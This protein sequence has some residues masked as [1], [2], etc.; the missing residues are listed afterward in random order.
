MRGRKKSFNKTVRKKIFEKYGWICANNNDPKCLYNK[1]L[2]IHHII[3]NTEKNA[4]IY[5]DEFLQS[6]S[7]G[8]LLCSS[9]HE[10]V[11]TISWIKTKKKELEKKYKK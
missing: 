3:P 1:G 4:K 9:C 5:G 8:I 7:N 11:S 6:E 10:N 2:S